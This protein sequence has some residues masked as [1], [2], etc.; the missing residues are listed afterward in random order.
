MNK[1]T[2]KIVN[3]TSSG[4]ISLVEAKVDDVV[5]SSMILGNSSNTSFLKVGNTIQLLFKESEV[6]IAKNFGGEISLRNQLQGPILKIKKGEVFSEIT[7][8]FKGNKMVSLITT[9]SV[10]RLELLVGDVVTGFIK[11]N[12]VILSIEDE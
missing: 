11:S 9:R 4:N 3:I 1:L 10:D 12:E 8:D 5:L 7:F 2:G 6:S